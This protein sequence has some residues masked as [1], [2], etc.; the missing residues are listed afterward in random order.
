MEKNI[1]DILTAHFPHEHSIILPYQ[2]LQKETDFNRYLCNLERIFC[3]EL[4]CR[5]ENCK[6]KREIFINIE[7]TQTKEIIYADSLGTHCVQKTFLLA[8][9]NKLEKWGEFFK[10]IKHLKESSTLCQYKVHVYFPKAKDKDICR[11]IRRKIAKKSIEIQ[12]F[13][14]DDHFIQFFKKLNILSL[15]SVIFPLLF[16][17]LVVLEQNEFIK[18]GF[19]FKSIDYNFLLFFSYIFSYTLFIVLLIYLVSYLVLFVLQRPIISYIP[20]SVKALFLFFLVSISG[21]FLYASYWN[22]G[23]KDF[24]KPVVQV[25][26]QTA[27]KEVTCKDIEFDDNT[28]MHIFQ[29]GTNDGFVYYYKLD[30]NESNVTNLC[31]ADRDKT[32]K[33]FEA[34]DFDISKLQKVPL[35]F[36]KRYDDYNGSKGK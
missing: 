35:Q 17:W 29:M 12:E 15:L 1:N 13:K 22:E 26:M 9:I 33:A 3:K 20:P 5:N 31:S 32:F 25:Y 18:Y 24:L 36:L 2:F 6:S 11:A 19:S 8:Y 7:N 27:V 21:L 14:N 28:S 34:K 10:I 4:E 30:A 23:K 16:A